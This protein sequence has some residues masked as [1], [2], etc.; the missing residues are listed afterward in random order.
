LTAEG[1]LGFLAGGSNEKAV[2]DLAELTLLHELRR[3]A[4]LL[5]AKGTRKRSDIFIRLPDWSMVKGLAYSER[6]S[7]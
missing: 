3:R 6:I 4:A 1:L 7:G 5:S 2:P